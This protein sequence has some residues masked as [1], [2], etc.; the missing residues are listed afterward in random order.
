MS[1]G[2]DEKGKEEGSERMRVWR[3]KEKWWENEEEN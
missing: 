1:R 3:E 2:G